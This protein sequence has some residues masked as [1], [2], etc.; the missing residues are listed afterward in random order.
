M[1]APLIKRPSPARLKR[2]RCYAET[3]WT[4]SDDFPDLVLIDGRFRVLCAL[5]SVYHTRGKDVEILFD[6]YINRRDAYKG[7]EQFATI[8]RT[9]GNM[10]SLRPAKF[11]VA[12]LNR[13][14]EFYVSQTF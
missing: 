9:I 12:D 3:P 5:V 4:V 7:V 13:A 10:V 2:W 8:E 11:E 1:G 6:D 14:I